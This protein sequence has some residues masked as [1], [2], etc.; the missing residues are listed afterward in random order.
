MITYNPDQF[1]QSSSDDYFFEEN[2]SYFIPIMDL[3]TDRIQFKIKNKINANS[4]WETCNQIYLSQIPFHFGECFQLSD[5]SIKWTINICAQDL[6]NV[7]RSLLVILKILNITGCLKV[8]WTFESAPVANWH[9][10][11]K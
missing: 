9:I 4:N 11:Q 1:T 7:I 10:D 2:S 6:Q 8:E 3:T 5:K